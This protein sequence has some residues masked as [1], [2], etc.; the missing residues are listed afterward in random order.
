MKYSGA[1][2]KCILDISQNLRYNDGVREVREMYRTKLCLGTWSGFGISIEEQIRLFGRVGFDGFFT[3]WD[4]NLKRYREIADETGLLYQSIHAPFKNAAKMWEDG[5]NAAAATEELLR[6]VRDCAEVRVP[7]LIVHPYIGFEKNV[8]PTACGVEHFRI[9]A[10][11]AKRLGVR[12]ALENVEGEAFLHALTES[13]FE[14]ENVGFCWDSGHELCYNRGVD[15]LKLYG[16]RLIATHLNDNLG[17]SRY[18]GEIY[19]TDDLH[20]LPFDGIHDWKRVADRLNAC[21]YRGVLTFELERNSK[22]HRHENDKY[23]KMTLEEYVTEC[24]IRACKVAYL[25][26]GLCDSFDENG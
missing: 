5:A 23:G 26:N 13:L 3:D 12:I 6:C 7:I 15:Q 11:E 14:Y 19:W 24:Y 16:D 8:E 20:L 25:K 2:R 1:E 9:V 18:D 10:E 22:P 4:Q 17:V 21:G